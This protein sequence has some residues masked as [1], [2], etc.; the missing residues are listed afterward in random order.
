M[1]VQLQSGYSLVLAASPEPPVEL[2]DARV[3]IDLAC[4][5]SAETKRLDAVVVSR[6]AG[7]VDLVKAQPDR[8]PELHDP[9]L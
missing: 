4:E 7:I 3:G 5:P 1:L 2:H 9:V 8:L 6:S